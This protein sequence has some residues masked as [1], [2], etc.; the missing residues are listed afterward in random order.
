MWD[1]TFDAANA[2]SVFKM[3][4]ND[5]AEISFGAITGQL[6][7]YGK[8]IVTNAVSV[9]QVRVNGDLSRGFNTGYKN[10]IPNGLR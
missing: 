8:I 3:A 2:A 10:K 4:V 5:P 1:N 9:S 6:Q 7:Y